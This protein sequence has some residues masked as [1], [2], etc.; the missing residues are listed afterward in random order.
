LQLAVTL[1]IALRNSNQR[2]DFLLSRY[3]D[4][5]RKG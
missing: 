3:S 5:E 2:I 4:M 1:L